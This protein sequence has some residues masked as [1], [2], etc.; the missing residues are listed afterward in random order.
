[1]NN[2]QERSELISAIEHWKDLAEKE[3]RSKVLDSRYGS[4]K[5]HDCRIDLY[6]RT[7]RAIEIQLD[8]GIAV[9]SC[10][11]KPLGPGRTHS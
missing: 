4:T 10:C 11:F 9:C 2:S 3:R 7:A 1:M 6:E 8:T 5:S